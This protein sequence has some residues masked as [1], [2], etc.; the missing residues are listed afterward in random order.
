[1]F[2]GLSLPTTGRGDTVQRSGMLA[3]ESVSKHFGGVYALRNVSMHCKS[4]EIIGLI[5]PNGA[6]KTTLMNVISGVVVPSSGSISLFGTPLTGASA[7]RCAIVGIGRTFQNVRL[8]GRLTVRQN[9]EVAHTTC[10]A[11][12]AQRAEMVSVDR[13][14]EEMGLADLADRF[15]SELAYGYQRRLEIARALALAPDI[16]LLDEPAAGMN[17]KESDELILS[18]RNIRDNY[19]C[20]VIVID[21][22]MRFIMKVCERISVL[23]LGEIIAEGK[24]EEIQSNPAVIEVYI[25]DRREDGVS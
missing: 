5:G 9:I 7:S 21:H 14:M 23:H 13:I 11:Q 22:D 2:G 10:M 3:V 25:G 15:S 20:G 16:L 18:V 24:P 8:F 1:M 6:G 17:H 12:R 4:G 19:G